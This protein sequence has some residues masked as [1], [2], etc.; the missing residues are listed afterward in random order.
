MNRNRFYT[1]V[2]VAMGIAGL[3]T[4]ALNAQL[5][6]APASSGPDLSQIK[7]V[8]VG[9]DASGNEKQV[10]LERGPLAVEGAET[11]KAMVVGTMT[12]GLFGSVA[13]NFSV[14]GKSS[15]AIAPTTMKVICFN[16]YSQKQHGP[17]GTLTLVKLVEDGDKRTLRIKGEKIDPKH[18]KNTS[19]HVKLE[20]VDDCW[21]MLFVQPL[22]AGHYAV[23]IYP[24]GGTPSDYWD[25]DVK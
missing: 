20:K 14:P 15:D 17:F 1:C 6:G 4:S 23:I 13:Y 18:T 25:F 8:L 5:P 9:V 3:G 10:S 19:D 12:G 22:E 2:F 7:P 21:K 16:G 11:G 24:K